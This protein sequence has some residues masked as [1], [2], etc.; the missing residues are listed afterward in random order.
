MRLRNDEM[1]VMQGRQRRGKGFVSGKRGSSWVAVGCRQTH[2]NESPFRHLCVRPCVCVGVCV[3]VWSEEGR[4]K[5][6]ERETVREWLRAPW[7]QLKQHKMEFV[8]AQPKLCTFSIHLWD[9]IDL[10]PHIFFTFK[11]VIDK[12]FEWKIKSPCCLLV[13]ILPQILPNLLLAVNIKC[14]GCHHVLFK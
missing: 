9:R 6:R 8:S 1:G 7:K 14:V 3:S 11:V 2:T 12:P 10:H 13:E 5:K 4:E